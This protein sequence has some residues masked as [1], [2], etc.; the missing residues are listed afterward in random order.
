M[1]IRTQKHFLDVISDKNELVIE[2]NIE[3]ILK[4]TIGLSSDLG[5]A[6]ALSFCNLYTYLLFGGYYSLDGKFYLEENGYNYYKENIVLGKADVYAMS[7]MLEMLLT[8]KGVENYSPTVFFNYDRIH[9]TYEPP[10]KKNKL[11]YARLQHV[12]YL[13]PVNLIIDKDEDK[14]FVYDTSTG[15]LLRLKNK[16]KIEL[17]NGKGSMDLEYPISNIFDAG[18]FDMG[19]SPKFLSSVSK[20]DFPSEQEFKEIIESDIQYFDENKDLL[21]DFR[22]DIIENVSM[23]SKIIRKKG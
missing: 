20:M 16:H 21:D 10:I 9:Q 5:V 6:S 23:V 11:C 4:K 22:D 19:R 13:H 12:R 7:D 18:S 17:I 8:K 15:L 14:H 3:K 2:A 1:N